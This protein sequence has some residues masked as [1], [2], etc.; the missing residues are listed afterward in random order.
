MAMIEAKH[1]G[2]GQDTEYPHP[3]TVLWLLGP[4][5]AGKTTLASRVVA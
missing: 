4:T 3:G 5:S 2:N 1:S